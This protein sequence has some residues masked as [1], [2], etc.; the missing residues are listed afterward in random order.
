MI[1]TRTAAIAR[2]ITW[3]NLMGWW[4]GGTT[5]FRAAT[6]AST[7]PP[8]STV[9]PRDKPS[10]RF[11]ASI[12]TSLGPPSHLETTCLRRFRKL[13]LNLSQEIRLELDVKKWI[14]IRPDNHSL[15]IVRR[16]RL[17]DARCLP[18]RLIKNFVQNW[19]R[20]ACFRQEVNLWFIRCG[21]DVRTGGSVLMNQLNELFV[22]THL[23]GR[24]VESAS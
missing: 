13:R 9:S 1:I 21:I 15:H 24:D 23:T 2:N 12:S 6:I 5:S 17:Q 11:P 7:I 19:R 8:R 22:L 10:L 14:D 20:I 18:A 16:E 3:P 4:S